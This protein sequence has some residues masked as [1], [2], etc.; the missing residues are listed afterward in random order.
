VS[1]GRGTHGLGAGR[2]ERPSRAGFTFVEMT[3]VL[4]IISLSAVLAVPMIEGGLNSREVRR[5][6]RQIAATMKHCRGEAVSKGE[7]QAL[8]IDPRRNS[9]HVSDRS[10]WA[11]LTDRAIIE[12]VDGGQDATE[13]NAGAVQILFFP[14]GSTSGADVILASRR[15][16]SRNRLQIHLDPLVGTVRVGDA[17]S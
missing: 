7:V 8:V 12:R 10:R 4:L 13:E 6:A 3:V 9:I 5:A 14:N 11:I 2:V 17:S 1:S 15:D 16:R